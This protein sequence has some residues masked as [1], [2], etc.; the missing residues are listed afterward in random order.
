MKKSLFAII[1]GY[2]PIIMRKGFLMSK[3]NDHRS[4]VNCKH[5][6]VFTKGALSQYLFTLGFILISQFNFLIGSQW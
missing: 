2:Q 1:K 5:H 6:T 4:L 3:S